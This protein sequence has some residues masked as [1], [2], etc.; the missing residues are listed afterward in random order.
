MSEN[1]QD[2]DL[3]KILVEESEK[4]RPK[5]RVIPV[6]KTPEI[7]G[8]DDIQIEIY[9]SGYGIPSKTKFH[10]I[11]SGVQLPEGSSAK[12]RSAVQSDFESST[13][14]QKQNKI[15]FQAGGEA[16]R[17]EDLGDSNH[18]LFIPDKPLFYPTEEVFGEQS[19][20]FTIPPSYSELEYPNGGN[21]EQQIP[22]ITLTIPTKSD[23]KSGGYD[24]DFTLTTTDEYGNVFTT[25]ETAKIKVR[26]WVDRNRKSLR[27][28]AV[29]V[30]VL[31]TF[32]A[33]V[34]FGIDVYEF[35]IG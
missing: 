22:P 10:V 21:G 32:L 14:Q 12:L 9:F 2:T 8:G 1:R 20:G 19:T 31:T 29:I 26:S 30:G 35:F 5:Y 18:L 4:H 16:V 28:F 27:I 15:H 3:R 6:V 13:E 7:S 11:Y 17:V 25:K 24:I 23:H 34:S 33:I